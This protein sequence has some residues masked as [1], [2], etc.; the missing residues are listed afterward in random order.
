PAELAQQREE[1]KQL[2]YRPLFSVI[3]PVYNPPPEVLKAAIQSVLDQTYDRWELCIADGA[4]SNPV[5]RAVLTE[6]A[7]SGAPIHVR[8]LD[9]NLGISE[10]SNSA[11]ALAQGEFI[12]LLDHDDTIAPD[13]LYENAL[14]L[15]RHPDA[16]MIYSD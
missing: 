3:M 6:A 2:S 1:A 9:R 14:L 10:N 4:S 15:N 7:E 13:A 16:D 8:F 5:V 12:V 11:L